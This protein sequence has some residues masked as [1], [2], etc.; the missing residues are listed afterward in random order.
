MSTATHGYNPLHETPLYEAELPRTGYRPAVD[1]LTESLRGQ[2]KAIAKHVD[3]HLTNERVLDL[4]SAVDRAVA[5]ALREQL[6]QVAADV[7]AM[8]AGEVDCE[9]IE[10]RRG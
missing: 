1:Y 2:G 4:A 8:Q 5:K 10:V 6:V 9:A 3:A 7:L